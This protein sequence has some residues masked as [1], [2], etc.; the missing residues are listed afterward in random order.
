M[1]KTFA[2]LAILALASLSLAQSSLYNPLA[3]DP[4][5]TISVQAGQTIY[6]QLGQSPEDWGLSRSV[7]AGTADRLDS[8][9]WFSVSSDGLPAGWQV[10][11]ASV[12]PVLVSE[13]AQT[14]KMTDQKT[15]IV[16]SSFVNTYSIQVPAGIPEGTYTL[17]INVISNVNGEAYSFPLTLTVS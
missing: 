2:T 17:N 8:M 1:W 14:P 5:A 15:E 7:T 11:L 10:R 3:V 9:E 4:G 12:K 6:V 13:D 16:E